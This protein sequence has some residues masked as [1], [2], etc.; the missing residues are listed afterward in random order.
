MYIT[1]KN[2]KTKPKKKKKINNKLSKT[3]AQQ[4]WAQEKVQP[5]RE[6]NPP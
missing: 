3:L 1:E 5:F 4:R 6:E 2:K